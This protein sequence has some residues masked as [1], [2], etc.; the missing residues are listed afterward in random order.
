MI[1]VILLIVMV[2]IFQSVG[3]SLAVKLDKRL[4]K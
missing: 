3:T 1:A 2:E 4:K